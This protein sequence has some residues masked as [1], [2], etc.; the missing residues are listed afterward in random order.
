MTDV[1][2]LVALVA[3]V[4]ALCWRLD[5]IR[6]GS[7]GLQAIAMT[8][9]IAALTLAF[10][11]ST[12]TSAH[13]L[14]EHVYA[15]SSRWLYYALLALGVAALV[16]VFFFPTAHASRERRA[17]HEAFPLV[18]ALIGLQVALVFTPDSLRTSS[19]DEWSF[20]NWGFALFY[21][22][23]S[24]YLAYGFGACVRNVF[25]FYRV[26]QGYLRFSLALL[27]TGF[28]LLAFAS[29]LQVLAVVGSA[30]GLVGAVNSLIAVRTLDIV[31]IVAFLLG[32]SFP[33]LHSRWT[34]LA[35]RRRHRRAAAALEPLWSLVTSAIPEVVLPEAGKSP[36]RRLHRQVIEIRD[37]LTQLSPLVPEEFDDV[38]DEVK[39]AM[40]RDAV[41]A[42]RDEGGASGPVRPMV[43][44]DGTGLD[45]EAAPL[46][47]LSRFVV[48]D[49]ARDDP[50]D[51]DPADY[52]EGSGD[53]GHGPRPTAV[54]GVE[55]RD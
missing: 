1:I 43:P 53:P 34:E 37:S 28:G 41:E 55:A 35:A 10:V 51:D 42:Y 11:V 40:L 18:V 19:V 48:E 33:M 4:L 26:S 24:A 49:S 15:G 20:K 46:I 9:A 54:R 3:F 13:F 30:S 21:I 22:I 17:G 6:R 47:R 32:I 16:I 5:K 23:A 25:K 38:D 39:V 36:T 8:V 14:D 31:G 7:G 2:N 29:V 52:F 45:A 44:A 12:R 27:L 50:A